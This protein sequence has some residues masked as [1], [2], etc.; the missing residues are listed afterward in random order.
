MLNFDLFC[1]LDIH[2]K[3]LQK[4]TK[5]ENLFLVGGVVR[6]LLLDIEKKFKDIDFTMAG[7]PLD[8]YEKI[9][10]KNISH[11][12]TEKF[13]TITLIPKDHK[14]QYELTPFRLENEYSDNRH[15]E[16]IQ[17]QN[18]LILDS[19]RR[20]FTINSLYY[21]S[22][23]IK[24]KISMSPKIEKKQISD[25]AEI[26]KSLEKYG[27]LFYQDQNLLI[28]QNHNYIQNLFPKGELHLDFLVYLIDVLK[29]VF[30][31]KQKSKD[32]II[33][34]LI[35]PQGSI[36]DLM[37]KKI[38]CV[39][40]AD[41]RFVEDALRTIRAL[42]FISV[43]NQKLRNKKGDG[44][45]I[46]F[47]IETNTW[48][49]LKNH[50]SL[51][52]NIAKERIK[53]EIKKVFSAGDP[54]AFISLLDEIKL[55]EYLFPGLYK[56][57]HVEQPVR[58]HPF[59]TY[60]HTM[61]SL[62]ELQKINSD[63]LVRLAILYHDVGKVGQYEAYKIG[64]DREE[65]REILSGPL[66]HRS[67][68]P[69][70]AKKD[71]SNLGFSKT[72]IIDI[73]RYIANH[74]VP[75][76][77]LDAKDGNRIK[78]IRKLYSEV[79]FQKVNNL[80]DITMADRL[81]QYNPMQNNSDITDIED[82]RKI[83]KKLKKEEGQFL[84]KDLKVDGKIIMDFFKIQPGPQV[85]ELLKYALDWVISDIKNRNNKDEILKYLKGVYKVK[86]L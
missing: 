34:I 58:Y 75:G 80:F 72:E 53:D 71:F 42:R 74:H 81:G 17:R 30:V 9:D 48:N 50:V 37:D 55:L 77:I 38:K 66:N 33:R 11:F 15:P 29:E 20:D 6:D 16:K 85:G 62:Y 86:G 63:Y 27:F 47:D 52:K 7:L 36:Q 49:S 44:K 18:D 35:D 67:S 39:G 65:I 59:D 4:K 43:L 46:L 41:N 76:E 40:K 73:M 25:M 82:L 26:Q 68:G 32:N 79:G 21:F 56:T 12:I 1:K 54:F 31:K 13:G 78:K 24:N 22:I 57:K 2:Q 10:K 83:L 51:V 19:N 64:L 14:I 45:N 60:V 84:A 3:Y 5:T 8:I 69:E 70:I 28:V 61:L 23:N